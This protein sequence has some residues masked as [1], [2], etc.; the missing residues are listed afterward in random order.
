MNK[1]IYYSYISIL[2]NLAQYLPSRIVIILN[3]FFIIPI[4]AHFLGTKQVSIYLVALQI[5]NFICTCSYDWISKSVLRFHDKYMFEN[6][7][8][9]FFSTT[10]WISVIMYIIIIIGFFLGKDYVTS[11]YAFHTYTLA[12]VVLLVIP[13]GIRQFLY[14]ILR[15]KNC[16][17]L[18]TLS[19]IIYQILLVAIFLMLVNHLPYAS[20]IIIA[21]IA[22]ISLI[23]IY[24]TYSINLQFPLSFSFDKQICCNILKYA[25]PMV[26]TNY[27]Y[28][29]ILHMPSLMF[30]DL[31]QYLNSAIFGI[32]RTFSNNIV[33][34]LANLFIFVSFPVI[35]RAFEQQKDI[36]RYI[37]NLVRIYIFILIPIV[38]CTCFFSKDIIG[39]ILPKKYE[40]TAVILPI[41]V[42]S[43]FSHE[44]M[45]IINLK[46]HVKV[47]TY[48]EFIPGI[49]ITILALAG[50]FWGAE[51][52]SSVL[53]LT[54]IMVL[55]DV[56]LLFIN[57]FINF[58]NLNYIKVKDVLKTLFPL[59]ILGFVSFGA[60]SF[61][62]SNE[63]PIII[64]FKIIAFL[65]LNY[66][67]GYIFRQK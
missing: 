61:I 29:A 3:S 46:Y 41:M 53:I 60:V 12:L 9:E 44:L 11:H 5:L 33:A 40:M 14:Q 63:I 37:T 66:S 36:G 7:I 35:M 27:C 23:D 24:I 22:A 42:F 4:F 10:F 57:L 6:R 30:Q 21:M 51:K 59:I 13:C 39:L 26:I 18:Y 32:S 47:T 2:K 54:G 16:Y 55:A 31:G 43:V 52:E 34:T 58:G 8:K 19:I 65:L 17:K 67:I 50:Y 48:I 64:I 15:L 49:F 62:Q 28:W 45:K 38:M 56:L 25:I 1:R 20:S